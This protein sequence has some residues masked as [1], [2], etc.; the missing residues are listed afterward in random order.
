MFFVISDSILSFDLF[1]YE[2]P[3]SH[4]FIMLTYYSAQLGIALSVVDSYDD[5]EINHRVIQHNDFINGISV[6]YK[7]LKSIYFE[8]NLQLINLNENES[9]SLTKNSENL[10]ELL[11]G[12]ETSSV[13]IKKSN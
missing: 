4:P 1:I 8:D 7:H 2:I 11:N 10:K 9:I 13:L 12:I 5:L 6:V 3:Y